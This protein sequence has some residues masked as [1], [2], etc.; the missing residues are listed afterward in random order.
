MKFEQSSQPVQFTPIT[1]KTKKVKDMISKKYTE[2]SDWAQEKL[3][4]MQVEANKIKESSALHE[5]TKKRANFQLT[6]KKQKRF[7]CMYL[8]AVRFKERKQQLTA[9]TREK[10][11]KQYSFKPPPITQ[12]TVE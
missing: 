5:N 7:D 4:K 11:M 2:D 9:D 10:E 8:E 12:K 1:N 3:D 6:D